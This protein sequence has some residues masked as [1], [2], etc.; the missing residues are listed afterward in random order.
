MYI[1]RIYT[2][3]VHISIK[4]CSYI[5]TEILSLLLHDDN[6]TTE[7][8]DTVNIIVMYTLMSQLYA[9]TFF[10]GFGNF[11]LLLVLNFAI[12]KTEEQKTWNKLVLLTPS[13][14]CCT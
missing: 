9:G 3:D 10:C 4:L 13:S 1:V 14:S 11:C 12:L 7:H 6:Q 8:E 5:Y 2:H